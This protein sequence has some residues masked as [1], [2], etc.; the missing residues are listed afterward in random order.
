M[1][2]LKDDGADFWFHAYQLQGFERLHGFADASAAYRELFGQLLFRGKTF[3][4]FD[5]SLFNE[6]QNV[7]DDLGCDGLLT[8]QAGILQRN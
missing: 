2:R 8:D 3:P 5:L 7:V 1:I 6:V 4:G